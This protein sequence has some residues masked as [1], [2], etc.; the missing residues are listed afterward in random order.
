MAT[1]VRNRYMAR[2]QAL[3]ETKQS[4]TLPLSPSNPRMIPATPKISGKQ[5]FIS[6][7]NTK[8]SKLPGE[9][10][11]A[12]GKIIKAKQIAERIEQIFL[13]KISLLLIYILSISECNLIHIKL[14]SDS[15]KDFY[16]VLFLTCLG[17]NKELLPIN[18]PPRTAR[19]TPTIIH[20]VVKKVDT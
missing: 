18:I 17:K 14:H 12:N 5:K 3:N 9:E 16:E 2:P 4:L 13:S 7:I 8:R 1:K 20:V 11:S 6:M 10:G 19:N 15:V